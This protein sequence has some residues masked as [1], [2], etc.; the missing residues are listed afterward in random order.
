MAVR[1]RFA[2]CEV[3]VQH[4]HLDTWIARAA[5]ALTIVLAGA[6][7]VALPG[8]SVSREISG[9]AEPAAA[10]ATASGQPGPVAAD[11]TVSPPPDTTMPEVIKQPTA[12]RVGDCIRLVQPHV[13]GPDDQRGVVTRHACQPGVDLLQVIEI[14]H[15]ADACPTQDGSIH[16]ERFDFRACLGRYDR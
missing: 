2:R 7:S 5:T 12:L 11:T 1:C 15:F 6:A 9:R 3:R 10:L 13:M 14:V 16:D 8:C 4:V